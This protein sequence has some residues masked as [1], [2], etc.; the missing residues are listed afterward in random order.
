MPKNLKGKYSK[1][2]YNDLLKL[3]SLYTTANEFYKIAFNA[4]SIFYKELENIVDL[5]EPNVIKKVD[6][7]KKD[8]QEKS[9]INATLLDPN[10][11]NSDNCGNNLEF[12]S[13]YCWLADI[14]NKDFAEEQELFNSEKYQDYD[15]F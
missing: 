5:N 4:K 6:L 9:L 13:F 7:I 11:I 3:S 8:L 12:P 1:V 10:R 14:E 2:K 15:Q